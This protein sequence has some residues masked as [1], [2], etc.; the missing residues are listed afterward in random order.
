MGTVATTMDAVVETG[1]MRNLGGNV[2]VFKS[3]TTRMHAGY[4][5]NIDDDGGG[6]AKSSLWCSGHNEDDDEGELNGDIGEENDNEWRSGK[7]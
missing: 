4:N 6:V 2:T 1:T 3:R 7:L 5:D